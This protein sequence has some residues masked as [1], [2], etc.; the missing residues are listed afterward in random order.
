MMHEESV[1][2]A[3]RKLEHLE[4]VVPSFILVHKNYGNAKS[5]FPVNADSLLLICG[6]D[7]PAFSLPLVFSPH[8]PESQ[9]RAGMP[10]SL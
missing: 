9:V 4:Y 3:G 1:G 5:V 8:Q 10:E 7:S 2:G 6:V